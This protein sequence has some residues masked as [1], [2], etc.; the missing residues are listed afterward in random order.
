MDDYLN[1]NH[2]PECP[3]PPPEDDDRKITKSVSYAHGEQQY[4]DL[5]S[6]ILNN[7]EKRDDRTGVGTIGMFGRTMR[8]DLA[9]DHSFP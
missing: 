8:F 9:G 1:L 3:P 7:G 5:L 4:L 6:D 2:H